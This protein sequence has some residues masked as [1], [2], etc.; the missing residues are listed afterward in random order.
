MKTP[1]KTIPWK[2]QCWDYGLTTHLLAERCTWDILQALFPF[3]PFS[4]FS[5]PY[6]ITLL[7]KSHSHVG[8]LELMSEL[9]QEPSLAPTY[10]K[11]NQKAKPKSEQTRH[12]PTEYFHHCKQFIAQPQVTPNSSHCSSLGSAKYLEI[13]FSR[14]EHF[15]AGC[16]SINVKCWLSKTRLLNHNLTI[17]SLCRQ[18]EYCTSTES[19]AAIPCCNTHPIK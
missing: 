7:T 9:D 1:F 8:S 12:G 18:H 4:S 15:T 6:H 14:A 10:N 11:P 17:Y 2:H 3:H 5:C 13:W 16:S 19:A